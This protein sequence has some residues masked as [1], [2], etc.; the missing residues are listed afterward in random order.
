MYNIKE[1]Y[2]EWSLNHLKKYYDS[3]FY[4][5]LFEFKAIAHNWDNVKNYILSLDIENYIPSSPVL[6]LAYKSNISFRVVHQLDPID[7]LIFT[8]L[9]Y[10]VSEKIENY[11]IPESEMIACS[12]RVKTDFNS[13]FDNL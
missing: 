3:D 13:F 1:N 10:E 4:P 7:S 8:A 6:N 12:Y 11:R 5:K 9:V 2:L